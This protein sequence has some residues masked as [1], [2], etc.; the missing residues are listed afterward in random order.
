MTTDPYSLRPV[1]DTE[2]APWCRM[3]ADTYGQD[4][5]DADLAIKRAATDLDRTI[6]AFDGPTPV[7][8]V[9][10]YPRELT[11]PGAEISTAGIAFVAVAP[12][13]R[14]RGILTAMMRRQLAELHEHGESV[15]A[16]RPAEAGIYGRYGYGPASR[17]VMLRLDKRA[18]AFRA[19]VDFGGGAIALA[20]PV[21]AR[22]TL[23]KLYDRRRHSTVGWSDRDEAA[24]DLRLFDPPERRG[25]AT[26]LRVAVHTEP[27]GE[28]TGYALYRRVGNPDGSRAVRLQELVAFSL[29]AYAS[30]W[31]FFAGFDLTDW[32]EYEAAVDEP[33][34]HLL[35]DPRPARA[36]TM[37]RLWVRLV[38]VDKA[39]ASRRYSAPLETVLE[40][41]DAVCPW[42]TGRF[43]L[44][45]DGDDVSCEPTAAPAELRL[46]AAELGAAYLGGTSLTSLAAAGLVEEL[47]PG[48]L[49][50]ADAAFRGHR[51]PFYPGGWAFPLY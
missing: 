35:V 5:T 28:V 14:R 13:H 22:S 32:I 49:G 33:L 9:S 7:G 18:M 25:D 6:G 51:E 4:L 19:D 15:A 42:N 40:V 16:L 31:R 30:L 34:P 17:G 29:P 27:G 1:T 48:A 23:T 47:S 36:D 45:A 26:A 24:W 10:I 21:E 20:D 38:D 50:R 37:D 3:I 12:T 39:L 2:F 46:S 8:G 43:R 11:V 44:L 41:E